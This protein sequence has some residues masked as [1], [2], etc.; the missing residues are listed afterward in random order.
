MWIE[1]RQTSARDW[2]RGREGTGAGEGVFSMYDD[3]ISGGRTYSS[4]M[5]TSNIPKLYS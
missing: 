1:A 3:G 4:Y 5:Y 2:S